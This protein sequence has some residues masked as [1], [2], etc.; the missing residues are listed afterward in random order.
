MA[1]ILILSILIGLR[2][3]VKCLDINHIECIQ[4]KIFYVNLNAEANF[5][6]PSYLS[7]E[8]SQ[9]VKVG[10]YY[11]QTGYTYRVYSSKYL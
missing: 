1:A 11:M 2:F 7:N 3:S 4:I 10:L 5:H 9:N 6:R 8:N